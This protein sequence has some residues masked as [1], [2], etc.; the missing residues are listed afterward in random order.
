MNRALLAGACMAA[1]TSMVGV[2]AALAAE[3]SSDQTVTIA[4]DAPRGLWCNTVGILILP[5]GLTVNPFNAVDLLVVQGKVLE[6]A[7]LVSA[8]EWAPGVGAFCPGAP[9]VA[10][11]TVTLVGTKVNNLGQSIP[12]DPGAIY[13]LAAVG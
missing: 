11:K 12:G 2:P 4:A 1:A 6:S 13:N 3:G 5:G 8:A 9:Q 7:G 10:G